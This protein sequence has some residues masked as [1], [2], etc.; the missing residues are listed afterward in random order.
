MGKS[1]ISYIG[2][3]KGMC[4]IELNLLIFPTALHYRKFQFCH[5]GG[6]YGINPKSVVL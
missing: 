5:S 3:L 1:E 4:R 2:K 6:P